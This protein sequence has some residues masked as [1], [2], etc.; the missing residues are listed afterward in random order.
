MQT[1]KIIEALQLT[2]GH[3]QKLYEATENP[4]DK[5]FIAGYITAM[6]HVIESAKTDFN[7]LKT[8]NNGNILRHD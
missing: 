6:V 1:K 8:V 4:L 3:C 2:V 7:Q 5:N